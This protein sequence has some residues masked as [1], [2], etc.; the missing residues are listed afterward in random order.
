MAPRPRHHP[1]RT[2]AVGIARAFAGSLIFALPLLMTMEMWWLGFT[3]DRLRLAL[4]VLLTLPVLIGLARYVGFER[5]SSWA[6]DV[7]DGLIGYA[8]GFIA[9]TAILAL[10]GIIEPGMSADEVIGKVALQAVPGSI[11]AVLA[12]SQLGSERDRRDEEEQKR[13]AGYFGE[14]FITAVGALF[15]AFNLAPT[16]E[17]VL[18]SYMMSGWH[19]VALAL[20]S[21]L[22]M[23]AF[24]YALD[25]AGG[26]MRPQ[27]MP[28]WRSFL[29]LPATGYA[30]CLVISLYVLWSFGRTDG[31]DLGQIVKAT[32]VLGF[33]AAIGGAAAR[34]VV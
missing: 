27:D 4:L 16:E 20:L 14:M 32:V 34:L 1:G 9:A 11:G 28:R 29:L 21:L 22:I 33:P 2:F 3:M 31:T 25:F 6:D 8:V 23:H 10:L 24:V 15:L 17:M 30:V 26:S 19:T 13:H 7:R 5:T 18:I 12:R